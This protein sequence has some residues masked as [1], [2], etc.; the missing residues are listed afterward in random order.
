MQSGNAPGLQAYRGQT[1]QVWSAVTA[2]SSPPFEMLV[3]TTAYGN[4]ELYNAA[5]LLDRSGH[6]ASRY[7][8]NHRVMFGE[9]VP[10][11]DWFPFLQRWSPI[12]RG[13][14]AGREPTSFQINDVRFS[15]N[16][17]FESTVPHLIRRQVNQLASEGKE[18]DVMINITNDGW[19]FGTSCLDL[20]LACNVFRSVEMRKTNL[21]CAN[22]GLSAEID[23]YGKILQQGPRQA[24]TTLRAAV[25]PGDR[26]S[27]YRLIGDLPVMGFGLG[28]MAIGLLA[29]FLNR[30]PPGP[31]EK[32]ER[33]SS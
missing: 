10:L 33:H 4:D 24:T 12:G 32:S 7:F 20:H 19:F 25:K 29:I 17:C 2:G 28:A 8:K 3:G 11:S 27:V 23:P 6:V 1:K 18:P 14:T 16:I 5:I 30:N 22:T 21:V 9:Y 31:S 15:P 26:R 13:L